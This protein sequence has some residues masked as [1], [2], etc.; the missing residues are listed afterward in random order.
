VSGKAAIQ[1]A[2]QGA[3]DSGL[4]RVTLQTLESVQ[5]GS[6]AYETG[7]YSILNDQGAATES[8]HFL[9]V[10]RQEAGQWKWHRHIWNYHFKSA[11]WEEHSMIY[12]VNTT[13]ILPGKEVEAAQVAQRFTAYVNQ[14][15]TGIHVQILRNISGETKQIHWVAT[16]DS[17]SGFEAFQ[18]QIATDAKFLELLTEGSSSIDFHNSTDYF[19]QVI[20]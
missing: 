17:L 14:N 10:W 15:F 11:D 13:I 6:L 8:G 16:H 12:H 1:A 5:D 3:T 4:R 7:S 9:M 20:A 19:Y 18:Q 2:Y